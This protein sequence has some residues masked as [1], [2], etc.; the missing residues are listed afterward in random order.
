MLGSF[1]YTARPLRPLESTRAVI[2]LDM[3]GR[4]EDH[5]SGEKRLLQIPAGPSNHLDQEK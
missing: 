3:I 4:N 1:F 2:N 5:I